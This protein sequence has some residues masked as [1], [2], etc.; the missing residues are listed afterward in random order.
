MAA[1]AMIRT[2]G[3][4]GFS[5]REIADT[6]G[7]KSASVHYHFPSKGDLGAAVARDYTERFLAG[8]GDPQ[9]TETSPQDLI[10]QYIAAYRTALVDQDLMCLCGMLGAEVASLP[11]EVAAETEAFFEANIAWLSTVFVRRGSS[12]DHARRQALSTIATLEGAM[13]LARSLQNQTTFDEAVA[14]IMA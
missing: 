6:V 13:I 10:K 2:R 3:Y 11:N 7:I 14:G 9:A 5:F 12:P 4:N 8:L 1:E